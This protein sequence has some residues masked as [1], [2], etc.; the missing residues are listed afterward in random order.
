MLEG[1]TDNLMMIEMN[2]INLSGLVAILPLMDGF[3]CYVFAVS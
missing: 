3:L 1:I 2:R